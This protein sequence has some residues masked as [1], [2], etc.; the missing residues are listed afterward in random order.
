MLHPTMS[1]SD[2]KTW[3]QRH[4]VE[5]ALSYPAKMLL[6]PTSKVHTNWLW[7]YR[8]NNTSLEEI[9]TRPTAH[10]LEE[11]SAETA[12]LEFQQA[13]IQYLEEMVQNAKQAEQ[14]EIELLNQTAPK[15]PFLKRIWDSALKQRTQLR[16]KINPR[17]RK[18]RRTQKLWLDAKNQRLQYKEESIAWCGGGNWAELLIHLD[19]RKQIVSCKCLNGKQGQCRLGLSAIDQTIEMLTDPAQY[20]LHDRLIKNLGTPKWERDLQKLDPLL[21]TE[22]ISRPGEILGWR[23]KET[24]QGLE[25]E[26]VWCIHAASGWKHRKT[27]LDA[28]VQH[29]GYFEHSMDQQISNI[30]HSKNQRLLP[31]IFE[32]LKTHP[33]VFIGTKTNTTGVLQPLDL[34]IHFSKNSTGIEWALFLDT[35]EVLVRSILNHETVPQAGFWYN[36]EADQFKYIQLNNR[37]QRFIHLLDSTSK[38]ISHDAITA[39]FQRLPLIEQ[40]IPIHLGK[41]L[42]G[43]EHYPDNR[44]I[45]RVS[46]NGSS[47]LR[48][49]FLVRPFTNKTCIVGA[50]IKTIYHFNKEKQ[51]FG[52]CNRVFEAE[53]THANTVRQLLGL[54]HKD[55]YKWTITSTEQIFTLLSTLKNL[56]EGHHNRIEWLS[57]IPTIQHVSLEDLRIDVFNNIN[58]FEIQ[59]ELETDEDTLSLWE[60]L[61][62]IR[63]NNPYL[64]VKGHVWYS[65]EEEFRSR[66][67]TLADVIQP[68]KDKLNVG[69]SH[70]TTLHNILSNENIEAPIVLKEKLRSIQSVVLQNTPF[71]YTLRPYQITG[72]EWMLNLKQWA[73]GAILADEMGLGKTVQ[74]INFL[75]QIQDLSQ[76]KVLIIAPK[77]TSGHWLRELEKCLEDWT[78]LHYQGPEREKLLH[79]FF[80]KQC[81]VLTYDIMVRDI[82]K[83]MEFHYSTIVFDEAQYLKN[84]KASRFKSAIL[85]GSN[86]S[87]AL[88]GT[89][90]ENSLLDLW[91]ILHV[92]LPNHLGSWAQFKKR[93]LTPIELGNNSRLEDLQKLIAPFLLRRKKDEVARDL[94]PKIEINELVTLSTFE[95]D[96]YDQLKIQAKKIIEDNPQQAKFL[97]LSLLTKLRQVCCHRGLVVESASDHSSKLDRAMEIIR[98]LHLE[99][100]KVLIFSQF[101]QLLKKLQ[102]ILKN[103]D[104]DFC[105]LDGGTPNQKRQS[106]IDR[107]QETD[108][109]IFLISLKAGGSGIN[110]TSATEVIHLDPWWNPAVEDQASDRAHR[111]GQTQTVTVIRLVAEDSI[112]TQ[113]LRLQEEKRHIA[114]N[115]L[116]ESVSKLSIEDIEQLLN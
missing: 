67:R 15:N 63:E 109:S 52:F 100:R 14:D 106:E 26:A 42:R 69:Y 102:T 50:G 30:V 73:R 88:T 1:S 45:I 84:P 56:P 101:V 71:A 94:P 35:E 54:H 19:G 57:N 93:F 28:L 47:N 89:P 91:A 97:V 77:S 7:V 61:P 78:I 27:D 10:T 29:G 86:F 76:E 107:F 17:S 113:I 4:R 21:N 20:H 115:L 46:S 70:V 2:L 3:A 99:N 105:Y 32:L 74:V 12:P 48:I 40:I 98:G 31:I 58:N 55:N 18:D 22:S 25:V 49:E 64:L 66:L 9:I 85:L 60:I 81:L 80:P 68:T 87:I 38:V 75:H 23:L 82:E 24:K 33:R 114:E 36:L 110:L 116:S 83:L 95:R 44:T 112:E 62:A 103:E 53:H 39:L 79:T 111:I 72:V 90:I 16:Q 96:T 43:T 51:E 104:L 37:I 11:A 8:Q 92:V 13:A 108:T 5:Y 65:I 34:Q 41:D 59:G 6:V